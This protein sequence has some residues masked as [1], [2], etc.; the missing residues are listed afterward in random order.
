MR[1]SDTISDRGGTDDISRISDVDRP[2]LDG[3]PSVRDL[4]QEFGGPGP[5]G[6]GGGD[7]KRR[8][9]VA[10]GGLVMAM[11]GKF[12][13]SVL[14]QRGGKGSRAGT[15]SSPNGG[16]SPWQTAN[17]KAATVKAAETH[18]MTSVTT[19]TDDA[20][21]GTIAKVN[22]TDAGTGIGAD[23]GVGTG[24]NQGTGVGTTGSERTKS[25]YL[26]S[27]VIIFKVYVSHDSLKTPHY[28]TALKL[29]P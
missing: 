23:T 29:L 14:R 28:L 15:N 9:D 7:G 10:R 27:M 13:G 16:G 26:Q 21:S 20:N 24:D 12:G 18:D 25:T 8:P 1:N 2:G 5:K 22:G 3:R 19:E 6:T 4:A 11:A 17:D